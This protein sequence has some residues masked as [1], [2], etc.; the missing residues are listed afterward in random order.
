MEIKD[1]KLKQKTRRP[2][3]TRPI[4]YVPIKKTKRHARLLVTIPFSWGSLED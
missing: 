3:L 2:L 4:V 1:K